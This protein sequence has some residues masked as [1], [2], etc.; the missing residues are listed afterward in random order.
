[1]IRRPPRSTLFPY[2]TLFRSSL[3]GA[4]AREVAEEVGVDVEEVQYVGS[5][6]WPFP[7][8]LMLGF[9]AWVPGSTELTLQDDEIGE[10]SWFR[11]EGLEG[12]L[13]AGKI[14]LMGH[15]STHRGRLG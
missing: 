12:D 3:E 10:A 11:R 6:P 7:R 13:K 5:Q 2:T 4:V 14:E 9:R 15:A 1:M 8:S